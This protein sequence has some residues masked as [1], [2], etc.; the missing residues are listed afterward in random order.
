M[1]CIKQKGSGKEGTYYSKTNSLKMRFSF[2]I[3]QNYSPEAFN[4]FLPL[5]KILDVGNVKL[6]FNSKYL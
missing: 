1:V 3:G 5:Q 4:V 6:D 2:S